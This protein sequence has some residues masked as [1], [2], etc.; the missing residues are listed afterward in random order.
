MSH[1]KKHKNQ[2]EKATN[3]CFFKYTDIRELLL[4]AREKIENMNGNHFEVLDMYRFKLDTP[5]GYKGELITSD[6]CVVTIIGTK[7]IITMYPV[8]LSDEFDKEG[9][10]TSEK[11]KLKRL[12]GGKKMINEENLNKL[13]KSVLEGVELTTKELNGFGF[14]SKDLK[15]LIEKGSIIRVKRGLY[16][17]KSV[18]ELFCYGKQLIA[19]KEYDRATQCFQKCFEIDP[20]H[21]GV[22]FQLFLRCVQNK[23]YKKAFEYFD[24]FFDNENEF[25]NSDSNFYLYLLSM[26]T[27][28]PKS[29]REYAK[30]LKLEDF[31]VNSKDKRFSDVPKQNKIRLSALNQ[32]FILAAKQ[33]NE[34]IQEKGYLT[35]QDII[36]K[37][38][39]SQAIEVQMQ[40]RNQIINLIKQKKYDDII[41]LYDKMLSSH[42]LSTF[43][44]YIFILTNEL[45]N[46]IQTKSIPVKKIFSTENIFEAIDGKNFELALALNT[47]KSQKYNICKDDNAISLLLDEIVSKC[48][49]LNNNVQQ[50]PKNVTTTTVTPLEKIYGVETEQNITP[51]TTLFADIIKFLMDSDLENS[52]RT[53]RTYLASINK[54]DY[55]FLVIDLIKISL[56]EKDIA[57]TKPMTALT[58]ISKENYSFDISTY[59]QEFYINL[60]QNKFEEARIYLDIVSKG[61]KLGQD[62]VIT[63]GL[64]QIL[65]TSEKMV[66]YKK[67]D[68]ILNSVDKALEDSQKTQTINTHQQVNYTKTNEQPLVVPASMQQKSQVQVQSKLIQ[69]EKIIQEK[70]NLEKKFI[71]QKYEELLDKKG[72]ILLKPMDNDRIDGLFEIMENYPNMVAFVIGE[73]N[74]QQL[75]LRYKPTINEYVDV[76]NLINLGNQAFKEGNYDECIENYLQ[77][78]QLF[79]NPKSII[80]SKLGFAYLKKRQIP[81]A[82]DYLT[83]ATDLAK[84][85]NID[86]FDFSDLIAKL[87]KDIP[88]E[89]MKPYFKMTQKDFDYS[90]VNDY[91]GVDNFVEINSFIIE[92]GLDV[93]T[94]CEKL[95]LSLEKI[96]IIKLIYAREF[97]T[98]GNYD[99][100]D[101]FLKSFEKSKNKTNNTKK[102]FE[103]VRKNK[104]FYQNRKS[105]SNIE[106]VFTLS[107][108]KK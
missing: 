49:E 77:L 89:D 38:L 17:L 103:D 83:I 88:K 59:I 10:S 27:E 73:D 7:D 34:S 95:G 39:L 12:H 56:L 52:F 84:K 15:D 100:G 13:Y 29:H 45:I 53:L 94:A 72:I 67:S 9:L 80:Y 104:R 78:L 62:C 22:C 87:K 21:K 35:V 43:D 46:I 31:K 44:N 11:L 1:I 25:Y 57:F 26:I 54:S 18:N 40:N 70:I 23:D 33:L 102:I 106:L 48:K 24:V 86:Y 58:L 97:Y 51:K 63:D 71:D 14:N 20:T 8:T 6:L 90:D 85:E 19:Q 81:I 75:V 96:D 50:E 101:M 36:I 2:S 68:T 65:E 30:F 16:S 99:R 3:G 28:L 74:K 60:S 105:G 61:N 41:E 4:D 64:Y 37:T 93:E 5:I 76:K 108:K 79:E 47:A 55:E 107:P 92:S 98:Q 66:D 91:Y 32:R 42:H 69:K 82:I